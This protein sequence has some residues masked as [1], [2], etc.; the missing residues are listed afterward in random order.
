MS[1]LSV[2][3]IQSANSS[4]DLTLKASNTSGSQIVLYSNGQ[5]QFETI[6]SFNVTELSSN[7][8]NISNLS[9]G[10]LSVT[11]NTV[12]IGTAAYVVANGNI[13]IGNTTPDSKLRIEGD[14]SLSGGIVANGSAGSNGQLLT[15]NGAGLYWAN[16][17]PSITQQIFTFANSLVSGTFNRGASLS[18]TYRYASS[19]KLNITSNNYPYSNGATVYL[20]FTSGSPGANDGYYTVTT[21]NTSVFQITGGSPATSANGNVT[22]ASL[23]TVT[24]PD[25]QIP[26]N[27]VIRVDFSSTFSNTLYQVYDTTANTFL[28]RAGTTQSGSGTATSPSIV[29]PQTWTK[30]AGCTKIL[31]RLVGGGGG[32]LSPTI[33]NSGGV[34]FSSFGGGYAEELI[35]VDGISNVSVTVGVG[36]LGDLTSAN[37][38]IGGAPGGTSS[39]G[40]YLSATGASG[41]GTTN[42]AGIGVYTVGGTGI[43]YSGDINLLG[44]FPP[45][46]YTYIS[47]SSQ[48]GKGTYLN[49]NSN[50]FATTFTAPGYGG[51]GASYANGQYANGSGCCTYT[52]YTYAPV[53]GGHGVVIVTEYY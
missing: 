28:I 2:A 34:Y 11:S 10:A 42:I 14:I 40:S 33:I 18:G 52:T 32:V 37:T 41:S 46:N 24:I 48:L 20:D 17:K 19:G 47:G 15:S 43:G 21:V 6:S 49:L 50:T 27:S 51:G 5:I 9:V 16:S 22:I 44:G 39:F 45:A 29:N 12:T 1:I 7:T 30:P 25:H 8:A 38:L 23:V 31:V 36:G 4:S 35:S 26:N 3:T 53:N 13:G